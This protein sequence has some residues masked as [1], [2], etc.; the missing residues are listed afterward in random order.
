MKF[1]LLKYDKRLNKKELIKRV[2]T[3]LN[4]PKGWTKFT[5]HKFIYSDKSP[6]I[7]I[8]FKKKPFP[9]NNLS[10]QIFNRL[11]INSDNWINSDD[12]YKIYIINHELGH[13][14]RKGHL[15][16]CVNGKAPL[17]MQQTLGIKNCEKNV[18]PLEEDFNCIWFLKVEEL[19][20][21][22]IMVLFLVY[23]III[24]YI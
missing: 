17:M 22:I 12:D 16:E 20:L 6:D 18:Y 11:Y 1:A 5:G 7:K 4:D 2:H 8:I 13:Y 14:Y 19:I 3:I 15:H 9:T 24:R 10:F 21:I 23:S